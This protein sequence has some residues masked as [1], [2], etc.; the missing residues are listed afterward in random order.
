M[1]AVKGYAT[2]IGV[3]KVDANKYIGDGKTYRSVSCPENNAKLIGKLA[4]QQG[5]ESIKLLLGSNATRAKVMQELRIAAKQLKAPDLFLLYF[6]GHGGQIKDHDGDE[7]DHKDET[8]CLYDG[9]YL[10]D[11]LYAALQQFKTGTRIVL[12]SDCCHSGG[13]RRSDNDHRYMLDRSI[14]I[15]I[16]RGQVSS[17]AINIPWRQEPPEDAVAAAVIF[18]AACREDQLAFCT[19]S[20]LVPSTGRFTKGIIEIWRDGQFQG[21]YMDLMAELRKKGVLSIEQTHEIYTL[22]SPNAVRNLLGQPAFQR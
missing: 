10:D 21:N 5:F 6:S 16:Y 3:D 1:K 20:P 15:P 4:I 8:W 14:P 13:I 22:G 11:E 17:E 19:G 9:H 12:I 18:L 7:K 2:I